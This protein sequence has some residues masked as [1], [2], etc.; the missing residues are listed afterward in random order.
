MKFGLCPT[1]VDKHNRINVALPQE[2]AKAEAKEGK[3]DG[4]VVSVEDKYDLKDI[5]G[6]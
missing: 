5:L 6:T 1:D 4:K 2:A 3:K